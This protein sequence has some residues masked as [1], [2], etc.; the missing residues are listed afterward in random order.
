MSDKKIVC[1]DCEKEFIF[2]EREQEFYTEKGFQ[3]PKRCPECR[4][5]RKQQKNQRDSRY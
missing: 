5:A 2:T 3:E 1:T 4:N